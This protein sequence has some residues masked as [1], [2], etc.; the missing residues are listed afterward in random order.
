MPT[1]QP[2]PVVNKTFK[3]VTRTPTIIPSCILQLKLATFK[4]ILRPHNS[5][6]T[7]VNGCKKHTENWEI[8]VI[9]VY[10]AFSKA[11]T[12]MLSAL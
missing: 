2:Y 6:A 4:K 12:A 8:S 1:H 3:S 7:N 5:A 9:F 10:F 11:S